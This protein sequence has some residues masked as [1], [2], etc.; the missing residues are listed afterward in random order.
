[1]S[2]TGLE[3]FDSTLQQTNE[4]LKAIMEEMRWD[5]R[6]RAYLALRG[7]L[8]ALRD[9]LVID[10]SAQLAA[11]LP[12][13][14]RG[15]YF[16][17]WNPSRSR[18]ERRDRDDFLRRVEREFDRADPQVDPERIAYAVF[19]VLA[20]RVSAGE[21]AQVQGMLPKDVRALWPH[22]AAPVDPRAGADAAAPA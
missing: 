5:D 7:T 13:L 2:A 9:Y 3:I 21:I 11:Q 10:E 18:A 20:Q 4:W 19:H 22:P 8:H 14:V 16:E 12:M 1:M 6:R 15:I 17:G